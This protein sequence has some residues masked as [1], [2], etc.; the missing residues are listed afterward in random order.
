MRG[1]GNCAKDVFDNPDPSPDDPV[2]LMVWF[3]CLMMALILEMNFSLRMRL[4]LRMRLSLRLK[5]TMRRLMM[6]MNRMARMAHPL[7]VPPP[8]RS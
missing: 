6:R 3:S 5:M 4:G 8:M 1:C 2:S 7:P